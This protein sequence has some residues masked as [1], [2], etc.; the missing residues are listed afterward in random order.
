VQP[1]V[2]ASPKPAVQRV[3]AALSE[4]QPAMNPFTVNEPFIFYNWAVFDTL[5]DLQSGE[6]KPQLAGSWRQVD[7]TTWEFQLRNAVASDGTRITAEDVRYS[8]QVAADPA[9]AGT[10]VAATFF[11]TFADVQAVGENLVRIVTRAPDPLLV[12]RTSRLTV[13][14][15]ALHSRG[16]EAFYA[17]PVGSGPFRVAEFK[18]RDTVRL[19][20]NERYWGNRPALNEL[21]LRSVPELG[22]RLAALRTGEADVAER[23]AADQVSQLPGANSRAVSAP[24]ARMV[25]A[26]LDTTIPELSDKRARLAVNMAIDRATITRTLLAGLAR[27]A[28][29]QPVVESTFGFNPAVQ[30]YPFDPAGARRLLAEAGFPNGIRLEVSYGSAFDPQR[31]AAEAIQGSMTQAGIQITLRGLETAVFRAG[32]SPNTIGPFVVSAVSSNTLDDPAAALALVTSIPGIGTNRWSNP[33]FDRLWQEQNRELDRSRRQQLLQQMM[34]ILR[35]ESPLVPLWSD[36]SIW[37]VANR[38]GEFQVW[39]GGMPAWAAVR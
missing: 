33:D 14:P 15:Q 30:A 7:A 11:N 4:I 29:G 26:Y 9:L 13:V 31:I 20:P 3:T 16:A 28:Q 17:A 38:V 8:W 25:T 5:V 2:A 21:T 22:T 23:L 37:G 34:T 18:T 19:V 12:N 6:P 1:T 39:P 10:P 24:I 36:Y 27:P 32:F 35:E